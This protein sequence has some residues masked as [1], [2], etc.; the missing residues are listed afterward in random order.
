MMALP[1]FLQRIRPLPVALLFACIGV[2][3][4][5]W[6]GEKSWPHVWQLEQQLDR[7]QRANDAR[8]LVNAE[9]EAEVR[10]L[11]QGLRAVEELARYEIGLMMPGE[12]FVMYV[13]PGTELSPE[14]AQAALAAQ[15]KGARKPVH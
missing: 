3:V 9:L 14:Q 2:Q 7:A 12:R 4:P 5:L 11:S 1:R 6:Y 15:G 8:R 10:D 13:K